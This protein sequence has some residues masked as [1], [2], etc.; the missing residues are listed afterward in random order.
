MI[1][2]IRIVAILL[3]SAVCVTTSQAGDPSTKA[4]SDEAEKKKKEEREEREKEEKKIQERTDQAWEKSM[5]INRDI[6]SLIDLWTPTSALKILDSN[7]AGESLFTAPNAREP[8]A[9][10]DGAS[11]FLPPEPSLSPLMPKSKEPTPAAPLAPTAGNRL[12]ERSDRPPVL[13]PTAA[14]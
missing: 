5:K 12:R 6:K 8:R 13:F 11:L 10:L 7:R 3:V 1:R 9:R 4:A 2:I 14:R